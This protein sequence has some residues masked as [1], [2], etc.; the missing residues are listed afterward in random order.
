MTDLT[1][2]L[3]GRE[4][5]DLSCNGTTLLIRTKCGTDITVRWVDH[6]GVAI[7]GKPIIASKGFRLNCRDF[8]GL[9]YGP[10]T[11]GIRR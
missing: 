9:V 7:K 11:S 5:A 1:R 3:Q 2:Q 4:I 6:N 8:S 10:V